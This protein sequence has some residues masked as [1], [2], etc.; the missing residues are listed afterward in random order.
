MSASQNRSHLSP[1]RVE[2]PRITPVPSPTSSATQ[3]SQV[4]RAQIYMGD[5]DRNRYGDSDWWM[6]DGEHRGF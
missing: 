6:A 4:L 1:Y 2:H 3:P 5:W